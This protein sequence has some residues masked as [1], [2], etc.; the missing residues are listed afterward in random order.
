MFDLTTTIVLTI[1]LTLAAIVLIEILAR[2]FSSFSRDTKPVISNHAMSSLPAKLAMNTP[3]QAEQAIQADIT[4][5]VSGSRLSRS[6]VTNT[7]EKGSFARSRSNRIDYSAY[8][9]PAYIRKAEAAL[10]AQQENSLKRKK[11]KR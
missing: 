5:T 10:A 7:P 11:R 8:D 2:A 3:A 1:V 6:S 4:R 9:S